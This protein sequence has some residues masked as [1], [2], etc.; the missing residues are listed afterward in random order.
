[1]DGR[2]GGE[3]L[4]CLHCRFFFCPFFTQNREGGGRPL[5]PSPKSTTENITE[6]TVVSSYLNVNNLIAG[7]ND[8]SVTLTKFLIDWSD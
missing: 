4:F 8:T 3:D 7:F 6:L 2:G 5:G 1:M